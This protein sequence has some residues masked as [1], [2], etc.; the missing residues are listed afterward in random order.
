MDGIDILDKNTYL[1]EVM[2]RESL[3]IPQI[4]QDWYLIGEDGKPVR[5]DQKLGSI[6]K[7]GDTKCVLNLTKAVR[8]F[9]YIS[10]QS[11]LTWTLLN[12]ND[13]SK[14]SISSH[15]IRFH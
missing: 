5:L 11:S 13:N 12:R 7:P 3:K 14:P 15:P 10:H 8:I 9:R 6:L 2:W 4:L 1:S